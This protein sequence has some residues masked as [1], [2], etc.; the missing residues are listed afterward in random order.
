MQA[1]WNPLNRVQVPHTSYWEESEVSL[2]RAYGIN[3]TANENIFSFVP[4]HSQAIG[5]VKL[6]GWEANFT[7][8]ARSFKCIAHSTSGHTRGARWPGLA[9]HMPA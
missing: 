7:L 9:Q 1:P 3:E 2:P 8:H 5:K 6:L 4:G